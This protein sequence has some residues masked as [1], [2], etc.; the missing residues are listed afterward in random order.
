[1]YK[2][3]TNNLTTAVTSAALQ[4][5]LLRKANFNLDFMKK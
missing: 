4:D 2:K 5:H 1:M 3:K